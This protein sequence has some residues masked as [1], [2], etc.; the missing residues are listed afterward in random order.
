MATWVGDF[1]TLLDD[2]VPL[3]SVALDVL[4]EGHAGDRANIHS[5]AAPDVPRARI[6]AAQCAVGIASIVSHMGAWI[7]RFG[8][9]AAIGDGRSR[10]P[11]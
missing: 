11:H 10:V 7:N 1:I 8:S 9:G 5:T 2:R 3:I 6:C 4:L